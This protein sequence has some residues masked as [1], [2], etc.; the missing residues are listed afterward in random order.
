M[1]LC[2]LN[3]HDKNKQKCLHTLQTWDEKCKRKFSAAP[4]THFNTIPKFGGWGNSMLDT[5]IFSPSMISGTLTKPTLSPSEFVSQYAI[6]HVTNSSIYPDHTHLK[7][8][9]S[10]A[11]SYIINSGKLYSLS[12]VNFITGSS[13]DQWRFIILVIHPV[14]LSSSMTVQ[15]PASHFYFDLFPVFLHEFCQ[16]RIL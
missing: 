14:A 1:N 10:S 8:H 6:L 12:P 16:A 7:P 2:Y 9:H 13:N 15:L 4:E 3:L 5:P 11:R